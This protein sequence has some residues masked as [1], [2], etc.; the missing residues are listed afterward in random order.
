MKARIEDIP[1]K[2][3]GVEIESETEEEKQVIEQIWNTHGGL[4][5]LTRKDDGNVELVVAPTVEDDEK[6]EP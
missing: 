1:V 4:A 5:M 6:E 2:G 3:R